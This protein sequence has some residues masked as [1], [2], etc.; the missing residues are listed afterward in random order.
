M[1]I[2]SHIEDG[3]SSSS[4]VDGHKYDVFVSFR[5]ADT[6][7]SFS[8]HLNHALVDSNITTFFYDEEVQR[9]VDLYPEIMS[10]IKGS[11]ASLIVLSK[12]YAKSVWCLDELVQILEQHMTSNHI[13]V[14]IFY[15][16]EPIHVKNLQSGF[17]D[18][19]GSHGQ[20]MEANTTVN[21]QIQWAQNIGLWKKALAQVADLKGM[22]INGSR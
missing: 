9:G 3:A 10:A 15:H 7:Y 17:G 14:P 8:D 18:A 5:G 12:N 16:V 21:E 11:K 4:P 2:L 13:V 20:R 6:R 1:V 22:H 19:M